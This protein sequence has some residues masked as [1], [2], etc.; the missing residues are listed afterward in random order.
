MADSMLDDEPLAPFG[1]EGLAPSLAEKAATRGG[2]DSGSP[3]KVT[4][5]FWAGLHSVVGWDKSL[6]AQPPY[7]GQL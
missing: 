6:K 2:G 5:P 1:N 7:S 4:L 3:L